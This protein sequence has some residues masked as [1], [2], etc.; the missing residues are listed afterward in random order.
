MIPGG[1][2]GLGSGFSSQFPENRF[3]EDPT[4]LLG[5]VSPKVQ[6][7]SLLPATTSLDLRMLSVC[8]VGYGVGA[9]G[10]A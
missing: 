1:G 4:I 10:G 7:L 5:L 2:K 9:E 3:L 6:S 8:W